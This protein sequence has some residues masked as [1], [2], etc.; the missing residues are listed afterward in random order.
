VSTPDSFVMAL[1]HGLT[2]MGQCDVRQETEGEQF[3]SHAVMSLQG[4]VV[5]KIDLA[6]SATAGRSVSTTIV[7]IDGKSYAPDE[8][9][10]N[11][12][13]VIPTKPLRTLLGEMDCRSILEHLKTAAIGVKASGGSD[14]SGRPA[15][16]YAVE[17]DTKAWAS[18]VDDPQTPD[19]ATAT[20]AASVID[21]RLAQLVIESAKVRTTAFLWFPGEPDVVAPPADRIVK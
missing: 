8:G 12:W 17:Y 21:G 15:Q 5:A 14:V 7:T 10:D 19:S 2:G 16:S 9:S 20:M 6:P 18:L 3:Q 4:P 13:R 11:L 1:E